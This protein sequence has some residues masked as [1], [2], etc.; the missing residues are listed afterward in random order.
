MQNSDKR[1]QTSRPKCLSH[2]YGTNLSLR[3]WDD[4]NQFR[5]TVTAAIPRPSTPS[6]NNY[7]VMSDVMHCANYY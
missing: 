2:N 3:G 1:P 4:A 5:Y 7:N 6:G